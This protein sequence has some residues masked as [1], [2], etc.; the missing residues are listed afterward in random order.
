MSTQ[1]HGK[2]LRISHSFSTGCSGCQTSVGLTII[3]RACSESRPHPQGI[4][5]VR[6]DR[7]PR[8]AGALVPP[9]RNSS[10][11]GDARVRAGSLATRLLPWV[12]R[13]LT[14]TPA[15]PR[16]AILPTRRRRRTH[17]AWNRSRPRSLRNSHISP[18]HKHCL[19]PCRL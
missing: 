3:C 18:V 13:A 6:S 19:A 16:K 17:L 8:E 2:T 15:R 1:L 10:R 4:G 5:S 9:P 12:R 14:Q 11:G 7:L